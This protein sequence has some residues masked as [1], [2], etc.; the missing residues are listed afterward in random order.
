MYN[1]RRRT[2][3]PTQKS[4]F[5]PRA[6]TDGDGGERECRPTL[7]LSLLANR[8]Q[9]VVLDAGDVTAPTTLPTLRYCEMR[10]SKL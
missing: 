2:A 10:Q 1:E 6:E 3:K 7:W 4:T 8:F 9:Q 5:L